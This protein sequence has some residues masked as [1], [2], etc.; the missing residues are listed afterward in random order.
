MAVKVFFESKQHSEL[1]AVFDSEDLY[2]VCVKPLEKL[3]KEWR[4]E[5]SESVHSED[6]DI[7]PDKFRE[8][9]I[10]AAKDSLDDR[11]LSIAAPAD[12]LDE[13]KGM[14][15]GSIF[16]KLWESSQLNKI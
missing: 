14:D 15:A 8:A 5:L 1:V 13:F 10:K 16:R 6:M 3:A 4:M 2:N 7:K 9:V 12:S 11:Y